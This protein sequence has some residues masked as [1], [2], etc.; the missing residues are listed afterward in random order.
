MGQVAVMNAKV[1]LA[2]D[3]SMA[4]PDRKLALLSHV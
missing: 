2:Q 4:F 3:S 1:I